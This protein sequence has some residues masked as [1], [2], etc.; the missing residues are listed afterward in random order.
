MRRSTRRLLSLR[1]PSGA[2]SRCLCPRRSPR[3]FFGCQGT[4]ASPRWPPLALCHLAPQG[5]VAWRPVQGCP[6][7][8]S[9]LTWHVRGWRGRLPPA[10]SGELR[11]KPAQLPALLGLPSQRRNAERHSASL[12]GIHRHSETSICLLSRFLF[13][14]FLEG[15]R[16]VKAGMHKLGFSPPAHAA[17][18]GP[19]T[20]CC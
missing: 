12:A 3:V 8:G 14:F 11:W 9:A 18:F 5:V 10:P 19:M 16:V 20:F 7:A 1:V 6:W 13:F 15:W 4:C 2:S 17:G